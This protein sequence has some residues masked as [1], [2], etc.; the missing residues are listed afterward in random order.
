MTD[1][2]IGIVRVCPCH[3]FTPQFLS[4]FPRTVPALPSLSAIQPHSP[5]PAVLEQCPCMVR[6][7]SMLSPRPLPPSSPRTFRPAEAKPF[8]LVLGQYSV[9]KTTLINHL[10][11]DP[12]QAPSPSQAS[13]LDGGMR[14]RCLPT[15]TA[16]PMDSDCAGGVTDLTRMALNGRRAAPIS[17]DAGWGRCRRPAVCRPACLGAGPG[18]G[19]RCRGHG[20]G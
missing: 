11:G 12:P 7:P 16:P 5:A 14:C 8:V 19:S 6:F 2:D 13:P 20:G 10:L 18:A 3:L 15:R 9:G 4:F 1:R 17:G